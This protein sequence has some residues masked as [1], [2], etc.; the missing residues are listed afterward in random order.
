MKGFKKC[1]ISNVVDGT[2]GGMFRNVRGSVGEM[3]G[4]TVRMETVTLVGKGRQ[5]VTYCGFECVK[6]INLLN[7]KFTINQ[8]MR[9][10]R[11]SR[12]TALL[13]L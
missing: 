7:L 10:K 6:F 13:F 11:E 5:N 9:A 8:I 2:D 1:C 3:K 12:L 4:L